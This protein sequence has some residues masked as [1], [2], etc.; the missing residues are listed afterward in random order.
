MPAFQPYAG[1]FLDGGES[2]RWSCYATRPVYEVR[3]FDAELPEPPTGRKWVTRRQH[4]QSGPQVAILVDGETTDF[5][6]MLAQVEKRQV[7]YA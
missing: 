6:Q 5:S 4:G 7:A 3:T 2:Y 1:A